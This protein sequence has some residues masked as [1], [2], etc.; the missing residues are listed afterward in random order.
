MGEHV[1]QIQLVMNAFIF[2]VADQAL[3]LIQAASCVTYPAIL[4]NALRNVFIHPSSRDNFTVFPKSVFD[5]LF[6]LS[7]DTQVTSNSASAA[8]VLDNKAVNTS[9]YSV[10]Q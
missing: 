6:S 4:P 5:K 7:A 2:L 8:I 9:T 10:R 3:Y 1:G